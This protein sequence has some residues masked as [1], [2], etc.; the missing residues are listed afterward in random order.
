MA[1]VLPSAN[2]DYLAKLI[3]LQKS[4]IVSNDLNS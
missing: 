4:Q 2:L 1:A 3:E